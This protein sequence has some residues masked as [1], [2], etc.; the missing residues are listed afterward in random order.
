MP[1]HIDFTKTL[2]LVSFLKTGYCLYVN[3][4]LLN[5]DYSVWII[6][7][8]NCAF[9]CKTKLNGV[10]FPWIIYVNMNE[11]KLFFSLSLSLS[12]S[13]SVSLKK[14][15]IYM[16]PGVQIKTKHS[17][18][19]TNVTNQKWHLNVACHL[20]QYHHFQIPPFKIIHVSTTR[21]NLRHTVFFFQYFHN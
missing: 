7:W 13:L 11:I 6:K 14:S 8:P 15:N 9:V 16:Q 1:F 19:V 18:I 3:L 5:Y 4:Y 10:S 12:L 17:Y 2:D 21:V 20:Y